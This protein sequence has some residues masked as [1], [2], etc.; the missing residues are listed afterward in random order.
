MEVHHHSH[1]HGK[2]NWRSYVWEFLM[3]FLAVFCGFLAEYQLEHVI[4]HQR[5]KVYIKSMIEDAE[6]DRVNI[7]IAFAYNKRR[8]LH[9]DTLANLC[10]D[11]HS[12]QRDDSS[13]YWH[14]L[15]GLF[16][17]AV[18]SPT[19]R[20]IQQLKNAGEMRLI[21]NK[22]VTDSIILYDD[23]AK[24]LDDQRAY[25]ELYQNNSVKLAAQL[26][27]FKKFGIGISPNIPMDSILK[28]GYFRLISSDKA[29]LM[30]FANLIFMYEGVVQYYN[31]LLE[32]MDRH[33]YYLVQTLKKEY[34][35]K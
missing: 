8:I 24:K 18:I 20:T 9:L 12:D 32:M 15:Y 22:T 10:A 5:E 16:H 14:Y 19:E 1:A 34:H 11:Y 6:T 35:M 17:P 28:K 4:E 31:D 2:K 25:Y 23:M 27:N 26:F 33:A 29:K 3:L 30:E 7:K 13:I 21:R